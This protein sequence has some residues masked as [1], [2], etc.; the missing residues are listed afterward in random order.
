MKNDERILGDDEFIQV[1]LITVKSREKIAKVEQLELVED[2]K[3]IILQDVP[4]TQR[5]L[6]GFGKDTPNH[7]IDGM[8]QSLPAGL[9]LKVNS[10]VETNFTS[11]ADQ[12][13]NIGPNN[14]PIIIKFEFPGDVC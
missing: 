13:A 5:L 8:F 14:C 11:A 7:R 3:V 2:Y 1:V 9:G 10:I 6:T 4:N 12:I